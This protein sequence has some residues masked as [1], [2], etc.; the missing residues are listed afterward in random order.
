MERALLN[1]ELGYAYLTIPKAANTSIKMALLPTIGRTREDIHLDEPI[2]RSIH[3]PDAGL[4]ELTTRKA[5]QKSE[6]NF[7]FTCVRNTWSR[8]ES[9]YLDKIKRNF[10][11]S[12]ADY[13]F[14]PKTTFCEFVDTICETPDEECEIHFR[15]QTRFL[16]DKGRFLPDLVLRTEALNSH[17]EVLR[18]YFKNQHGVDIPK[19]ARFGLSTNRPDETLYDQSTVEKIARRYGEEIAMF[20]FRPPIL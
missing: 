1:R 17:W 9:C 13:S 6:V 15:P 3:N 19:I 16:Y 10:L 18:C 7:V 12:Y 8:L 20:G 14:S 2:A 11:P 5:V 4:Y